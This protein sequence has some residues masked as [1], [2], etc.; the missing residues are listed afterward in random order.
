VQGYIPSFSEILAVSQSRGADSEA[1]ELWNGLVGWWPFQERGGTTAFDVSGW[2]NNGALTNS[3]TW[4]ISRLGWS[5]YF[6]GGAEREVIVGQNPVLVGMNQLTLASWIR[7]TGN[8]ADSNEKSVFDCW[9]SGDTNYLLRYYPLG[10]QWQFYVD[11]SGGTG[12]LAA[13]DLP[14]VE[15]GG[16][17]FLTAT[18]DGATMRLSLDGVLSPTTTARTGSI[19]AGT[20]DL[21]IGG[22][23][24]GSS[25]FWVGYLCKPA[26]W[27]R[28]LQHNEHQQLYAN[29]WAM[30]T[31]RRRVFKAVAAVGVAPTSHLY[32]SLVGPLGGPI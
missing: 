6:D 4:A 12:S 22:Q 2:G 31:L 17:H 1:L 9:Q 20:E 24:A 7:Y 28:A 16:W 14:S 21:S 23:R 27:S 8:A 19:D 11:T 3:P 26:M 15:D 32:G 13:S 30:G 29:P 10:G 18:Y 25:D 5:L